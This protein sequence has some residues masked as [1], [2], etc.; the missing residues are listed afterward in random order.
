MPIGPMSYG[1]GDAKINS[2][3]S[4]ECTCATISVGIESAA[5]FVAD[6]LLDGDCDFD[7]D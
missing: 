3:L 7:Y 6:C 4:I 1:A 5:L 2:P